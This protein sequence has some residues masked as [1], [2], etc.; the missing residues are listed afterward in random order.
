MKPI[1]KL[2]LLISIIYS[3]QLSAQNVGI[4]TPTPHASALLEVNSTSKGVLIPALT[5][6][7]RNAI[8]SPAKGL[9]VFVTDDSSFHYNAGTP[10]AANWQKVFAG[11]NAWSTTGNTGNT[12]SHFIGTTDT[13]AVRFKVNNLPFG[14]LSQAKSNIALGEN[15]LQNNTTGTSNVAIGLA[16]MKNNTIRG[17]TVA[18]GD[19]ALYNN[20][21]GAVN[22][23]DGAYN[24]AVG[25]RALLKNTLGYGNTATG[26]QTLFTNTTGYENTATGI[27]ALFSN[28][29]GTAN[30]AYGSTTL[31]NNISGNGNTAAGHS[32]MALNLLGSLNVAVGN[33]A[34]YRNNYRSNL[35]AIGDSALYN[36]G[37]GAV[38][39]SSEGKSNTAV[40]SKALYANTTGYSN[41]ANGFNALYSNISGVG[42]T[43]VGTQSLFYN[44]T[45]NLNTAFGA[46]ALASNTTGAGNTASGVNTLFYNTT[47]SNN[48]VSGYN[49]MINNTT[50]SENAAFGIQALYSNTTGASNTAFG[51]NTLYYNSTGNTNTAVGKF[52]LGSNTTGNS[53]VAV[54][55]SALN[56]N[57]DRSNLVAIGDSA[58]YNNGVGAT[59]ADEAIGNT[60]M[61]S[62]TL[63]SNTRGSENTALGYNT[64]YYNSSGSYNTALGAGAMTGSTGTSYNVAIGNNAFYFGYGDN[65]IAIGVG[66]LSQY[67]GDGNIAIGTSAL[68]S[69]S[70]GNNNVVIGKDAGIPANGL[71]NAVAIGSKSQANCSNCMV[72]GSVNGVNSATASINVGIGINNPATALHVKSSS[73]EAARIEGPQAYMTFY[74]GANYR[75]FVQAWTNAL[76]IGA[77][78][79]NNLSF[80]T[81]SGAERMVILPNG[82]VGI[83]LP[84]PAATLDVQKTAGTDV[85][86]FRGTAVQS[87]IML[88]INEDTYIRGGLA[89]S[90]VIIGD[91][92]T[93]VIV[94]A[95]AILPG[96]KLTVGG[97]MRVNGNICYTGTIAA[98]SDMR[99]KTNFSSLQN[100]LQKIGQ[101]HAIYYDWKRNEFPQ[102]GFTS[103]RQLG[104][105]AQEVEKLFPEIVQ[106][107][108]AG[109]KAVDY[110][111]LT[112]VLIE[113]MKEQQQQIEQLQKENN[114]LKNR[115]QRLEKIVLNR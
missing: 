32:A 62:K 69:F 23:Y 82:N 26:I 21:T 12:V 66:A 94:G 114:D 83:G 75:G 20:G 30:T 9:L 93:G 6:A 2:L 38:F 106:T 92:N 4:G 96:N 105:S 31:V 85:A 53:N 52:A 17:N 78:G 18:I 90:N 16:A 36:N 19:S 22:Y 102:M 35:V 39:I 67:A 70:I 97:N 48:T 13:Q 72:L 57:T 7:Q 54:G 71:N 44:T 108:A 111:R 99:Y 98:C 55:R 68:N 11:N 77:T 60:A 40:G 107:N 51:V 27:N 34:L 103:E 33:A 91:L 89:I 80:T 59:A 74:D 76:G 64:L 5:Q 24:T 81:N 65:N 87:H 63:Y 100:A 49:A 8:A 42:N 37:T 86:N 115:L 25:S 28:T 109:Y 46:T 14:Y 41:T 61:G 113:G 84:A 3:Q 104:L 45:G 73:G 47:G 1:A 58:L 50:G 95:G 101:L 79:G 10:A 88:G 112:P 15:A 56:A 110:S 29:T 43:A